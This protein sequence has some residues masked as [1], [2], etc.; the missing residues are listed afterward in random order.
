MR[1]TACF[2]ASAHDPSRPRSF[3]RLL[4]AF[5]LALALVACGGATPAPGTPGD[6]DGDGG[7]GP[8]DGPTAPSAEPVHDTIAYVTAD[9]DAIRLVNPD[10]GDDRLLWA[11]G[12]ADPEGVHGV[13][14]TSWRP[15][16]TELAF[17]S[18]HE[19]SCSLYHS[20][21]FVIAADGADVR[22]VTQPPGCEALADEPT[23][24]VRVPVRND[25][26]DS[27]SG[28]FYFQGAP[29]I[30]A[31]N[32]PP[33]G[34]TILV[35]EEVADFGDG[36]AGIQF[37]TVIH[38][39]SREIAASS[40]VDVIA[41][42]TVTTG[43][44][45][46]FVPAAG[47]EVRDATWSA[48]GE[49]LGYVLNFASLWTSDPFPEPLEFGTAILPSEPDMPFLANHLAWGPTEATAD[50]LLYAGTEL[51][52]AVSIYRVA[53]AAGDAGEPLVSFPSTDPVLGLAWLP[54]GSGLVYAVAEGDFFGEERAGNL[55]LLRFGDGAPERLTSF[56][57]EFA[58]RLA[59]APE[60]DRIVFERA[61]ALDAVGGSSLVEPDLWLLSLDGGEPTLL[62]EGAAAPSWSW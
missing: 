12:Q 35:F 44:V 1:R 56:T 51:G 28:F 47:W 24:T 30:Q 48:D 60:G 33:G 6:G 61:D 55:F 22:R 8:G 29:G 57:G 43:S 34:S 15:D 20:D 53:E 46:V 19:N 31:V 62:V 45:N 16:A 23:G 41:G 21:V 13:W 38:G 59:V 7:D 52:D 5:L 3:L 50:Q 54:D 4:A 18:T 10:G 27:F 42:G 25:G 39:A 26:F 37:G 11:H 58:G 17:V 40:A 36:D 32:L 9:G 49:R 2:P 14:S